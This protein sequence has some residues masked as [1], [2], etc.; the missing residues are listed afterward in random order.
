MKPFSALCFLFF[1]T[2]PTL[3]QDY[4]RAELFTGYTYLRT[5]QA[6]IDLTQVGLAGTASRNR[7]DHEGFNIALT[8][9]FHPNIGIVADFGGYYG[10]ITYSVNSPLLTD[11]MNIR[12]RYYTFL[13]GPQFYVRG[14]R[15][16]LFA[17]S[18]AGIARGNQSAE[19]LGRKLFEPQNAFAFASGAGLDVKLSARVS[20]RV[21]QGDYI[22]SRLAQVSGM[23]N[24][25]QHNFRFSTGIVFRSKD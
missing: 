8:G 12:S 7:G 22:M 14:G 16:M 5:G 20:I 6:T 11:S 4:P 25:T 17:R 24:D 21:I 13:F 2:L 15:V 19:I 9:N 10:R 3:A 23:G 1:L 18:M